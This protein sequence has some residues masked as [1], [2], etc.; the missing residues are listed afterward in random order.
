MIKAQIV[1]LGLEP[2][3]AKR[4]R[5]RI[6][7]WWHPILYLLN[8]VI[9][10]STVKGHYEICTIDAKYFGCRQESNTDVLMTTIS[11]SHKSKHNVIC[12]YLSFP[13]F[14]AF[15]PLSRLILYSK[16]P[17]LFFKENAGNCI[18]RLYL[19]RQLFWPPVRHYIANLITIFS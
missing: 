12:T 19:G 3:V 2:G 5:R 1:C 4:R 8:F 6:Q 13:T 9:P 10:M 18:A 17:Y 15:M 7:L 11:F 14:Y 16:Y